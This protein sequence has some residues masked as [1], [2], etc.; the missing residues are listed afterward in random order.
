MIEFVSLSI[1]M[2]VIVGLVFW[3]VIKRDNTMRRYG[4]AASLLLL[5]PA[6]FGIYLVIGS[7]AAINP[8]QPTVAPMMA[9]GIT[10]DDINNMVARLEERLKGDTDDVEGLAMLARSYRVKGELAKSLETYGRLVAL[11][12]GNIEWRI[13]MI[14][15]STSAQEGFVDDVAFSWIE[16]ALEIDP[17]NP[18]LLWLAG[19]AKVQRQQVEQAKLY[20]QQLLPLLDGKPQQTELQVLLNELDRLDAQQ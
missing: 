16:Q 20:W 15:I 8:K 6:T 3:Q 11:E 4:V 10:A 12:P 13:N 19:L 1:L 9:E 7:P 14:D 17:Q 5:A 2:F 18:N